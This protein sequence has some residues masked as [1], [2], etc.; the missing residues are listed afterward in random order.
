MNIPRFIGAFAVAIAAAAGVSA[1]QLEAQ[2]VTTGAVGGIVTDSAGNPVGE[3]QIRVTNKQTGSGAGTLTRAD[4]RY[5]LQG[6]EVGGPYEI[7]ARRI[8]FAPATKDGQFIGLSVTLRA[9]FTLSQQP[10]QLTGVVI[11][12]S[13]G[14]ETFS[15]S[16]LGTKTIVSDSAIQRVPTLS[17]NLTDFIRLTPQVSTA[18]AGFSG[19]GCRTE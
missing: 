4:G 13:T 19:G 8:G 3:V 2:S 15:S 1:R 17:R 10:T 9:D 6:L 11:A 18:G 16:N 14:A 12:A 5:F 7:V